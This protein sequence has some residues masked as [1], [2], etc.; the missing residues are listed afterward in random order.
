M[1]SKFKGLRFAKIGNA[2]N[3]NENVIFRNKRGPSGAEV[4]VVD[5]SVEKLTES[6]NAIEE[7]LNK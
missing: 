7:I 6:A 1:L 4:I 3:Q 5:T 2:G